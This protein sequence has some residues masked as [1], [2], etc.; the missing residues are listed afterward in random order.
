MLILPKSIKES[1]QS[2][3]DKPQIVDR[4]TAL[5]LAKHHQL[6]LVCVSNKSEPIVCKLMD[7]HKET[8][9]SKQKQKEKKSQQP[10]A[11]VKEIRMKAQIDQNDFERKANLIEKIIEVDNRCKI[12]A[13]ATNKHL[14]AD[15][16]CI[17]K[18]TEKIVKWGESKKL[19][20]FEEQSS[21]PLQRR[22]FIISKI[23]E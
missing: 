20:V 23:N 15:P 2:F 10:K 16:Q 14:R 11:D 3:N 13:S 1:D 18:I 21:N 19:K 6:D 7:F 22:K 5:S 4:F 17:E 8:F 12:S 9:L